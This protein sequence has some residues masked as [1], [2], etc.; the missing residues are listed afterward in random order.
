MKQ[1][2]LF[3]H[4]RA[5]RVA[6]HAGAWIETPPSTCRQRPP[7]RSPP[8]RGRGLKHSRYGATPG[9]H[10]V[11][12][13]AGA[14]IGHANH[15]SP[16]TRGR[17]LKR[18]EQPQATAQPAGSPPTRGRGL[19][20]PRRPQRAGG[21]GGSPPTR[22]RGLKPVL[23][24][25]SRQLRR[26]A[27]HAGAWIE[28]PTASPPRWARS[29]VAPHA[30]A[31]IET[32]YRTR[33]A[34]GGSWSPPTR[35]RGLKRDR[36]DH[37]GERSI[38][39]PPTRGRGLKHLPAQGRGA[40]HRSPPTRGRGLKLLWWGRPTTPRQGSPPRNATTAPPAA[41]AYHDTNR[42]PRGRSGRSSMSTL[43]N[44]P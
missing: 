15:G 34:P 44:R 36:S 1:P 10:G 18:R 42:A 16:P 22:G 38:G 31:W 2:R 17:G 37:D 27:P 4:H 43:V 21:F 7:T 6:P 41:P 5:R 33:I 11:A 13:H 29:T 8:T 23:R 39:S 20:L 19:K 24:R 14:W 9:Q 25:S 3:L 40:V 28:T 26:V 12:P 35:G 32:L 30:G